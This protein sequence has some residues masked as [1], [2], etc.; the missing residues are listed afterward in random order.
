MYQEIRIRRL[1]AGTVF[2]L[3]AI[4]SG[5]STMLYSL[6]SGVLGI[7]GISSTHMNG[8]TITGIMSLPASLLLGLI[9]TGIIT[10]S[11]GGC[12]AFGL[13]LYAKFRPLQLLIQTEDGDENA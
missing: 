13:W 8:Q 12:M 3:V 6:I 4:G 7:F 1:S 2:K 11:L 9:M 5:V 10:L